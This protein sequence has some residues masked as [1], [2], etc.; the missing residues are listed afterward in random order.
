MGCCR[1]R[2]VWNERPV[3]APIESFRGVDE[4]TI[5]SRKDAWAVKYEWYR[6][7]FE[8]LGGH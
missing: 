7:E 6:K 8:K 1:A 2:R 5:E 4:R 3:R